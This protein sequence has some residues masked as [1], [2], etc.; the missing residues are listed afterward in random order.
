M[1]G[2]MWTEVMSVVTTKWLFAMKTQ[3]AHNGKV[4]WY[5][6]KYGE[7]VTADGVW[8]DR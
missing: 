5:T 6:A 8:S 2:Q 7:I 4:C 3:S 1:S